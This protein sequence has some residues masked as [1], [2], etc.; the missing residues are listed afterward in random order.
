[1]IVTKC[2]KW[3]SALRLAGGA[4][5]CAA[6]LLTAYEA[7]GQDTFS[8]TDTGVNARNDG[9]FSVGGIVFS[10]VHYDENWNY[11]SSG[12]FRAGNGFPR[13]DSADVWEL[14]GEFKPWNSATPFAVRQ[15][16]DIGTGAGG[17]RKLD[18]SFGLSHP[19]GVATN[20][21]CLQG[22][23]PFEAAQKTALVYYQ[24]KRR[25]EYRFPA[26]LPA[27]GHGLLSVD[28]ITKLD[29]P[30][31]GGIV[32][33]E[34]GKPIAFSLHDNRA[35][36]GKGYSIRLYMNPRSG[37]IKEA[38]L[39]FSVV[40]FDPAPSALDPLVIRAGGQWGVYEHR[41]DILAGSVFDRSASLEAPAGKYG[42]VQTNQ[43]GQL[44]YA[45]KP[46]SPLR[47]W[48]VNLCYGAQ[49][50]THQQAD[51]LAERF[52][53]S[54]YN[55]VRLHHFDSMLQ[56]KG[57]ASYELDEEQLDRINYLFAALKKRGIYIATDL[58]SFRGFPQNEVP[59]LGRDVRMEI[60][61]LIPVSENAYIAWERFA[62]NL[63]TQVNPYTGMSW[64]EDPALYNICLV[65]E[66]TALAP[67][68]SM[69]ADILAL[70]QP[71]YEQWRSGQIAAGFNIPE[72][73][74]E[75]DAAFNRFYT[76]LKQASD[77]RMLRFLREEIGVQALLTS[78]NNISTE[79][80]VFARRNFDLVDNHEYWNH[81]TFPHR[82]WNIPA[83]MVNPGSVVTGGLWL[84]RS[85]FAARMFGKPYTITEFN[86]VWPNPARSESGVLMPAYAGLQGWSALYAF[87]Y[88][89]NASAMFAPQQAVRNSGGSMF[90]LSMDP[91]G[92]LADRAAAFLFR[93]G[94]IEPAR[95]A[96]SWL[97]DEQTAFEGRKLAPR[98]LPDAFARL[99]FVTRVGSVPADA[100]DI[101]ELA[102]ANAIKAFVAHVPQNVRSSVP[103]DIPVLAFSDGL[104][105]AL[106][107]AG[108]MPR[109]AG[110]GLYVSDTGQ[111]RTSTSAG[112][113]SLVTDFAGCFVLPPDAG[114]TGQRVTA[115]NGDTFASVYVMS[116]DDKPLQDSGRVLVLH[117]T[118]SLPSGASFEDT[119]R[120]MLTEFGKPPHLVRSGSTEITIRL[121]AGSGKWRAFAVDAAGKRTY[122]TEVR[123]RGDAVSFTAQTLSESGTTLAYELV[124]E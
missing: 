29:I 54:G 103:A 59:E 107:D 113:V 66:D 31:A 102:G 20:G 6:L 84:P 30:S 43:Q 64:A 50:L 40:H 105:N 93:S 28:G 27:Q 26:E 10:L 82:Q 120:T 48:G 33:I 8:F 56:R 14:Q 63:L 81:P 69:R 71:L 17:K 80:Q 72:T 79:A 104:E 42:R 62:R 91:V 118:D 34:A 11:A 85:L 106:V 70:Y 5:A 39:T 124:R 4:A 87:D 65:N 89:N 22:D 90:H 77:A 83:K 36:G 99:G 76:E 73:G 47:M 108:I 32:A 67:W 57:G 55:T 35:F 19:Q 109:P 75:A 78:D 60:K 12:N 41:L 94:G 44:V 53:M 100:D 23:I 25:H 13:T 9:R 2:H 95:G 61:E 119:S 24:G 97:A 38:G 7:S 21:L 86:F 101:A 122:E 46:D 3:F 116:A 110:K 18:V 1:M 98:L 45:D 51:E 112:T 92:L 37:N 111:I 52:A 68:K 96:V 115:V 88:A 16:L 15:R 58:Y 121:G 74:P 49:Y 123:L 117:L 114:G